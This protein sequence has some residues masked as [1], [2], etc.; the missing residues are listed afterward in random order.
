MPARIGYTV[1]SA[2]TIAELERQVGLLLNS[3][4]RLEGG[5]AVD[6][7]KDVICYY[8]ALSNTKQPRRL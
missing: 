5:V 7:Y 3:G 1:I 6:T 2:F 8:Q 4:W